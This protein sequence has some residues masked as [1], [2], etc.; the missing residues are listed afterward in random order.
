MRKCKCL[1]EHSF[2]KGELI[3]AAGDQITH[4][5]LILSGRV[6]IEINNLWGGRSILNKLGQGEIF[7]ESYA[8]TGD[9]LVVEAVAIDNSRI[10]MI[11]I[12]GLFQ[13]HHADASW[14]SK[15]LRK[16]LLL[17]AHKNVALSKRA[18]QLS[19]KKIR[20][21]LDAYLSAQALETGQM[22]F[23]I[24]FN[25]QELADYLNVDRSALSKELTCM[26]N[27]GLIEFNK[28]HFKILQIKE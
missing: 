25:R 6:N 3:L 24:P 26:R 21:R 7:G 13:G 14:H 9:P 16:V 15:L 2:D 28:N 20:G 23:D 10:L 22:K 4:M 17:S 19:S 11:D 18:F 5:G 1:Q 8:I 12:A 27:E